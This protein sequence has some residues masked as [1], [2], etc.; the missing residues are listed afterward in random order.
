MPLE[1]IR[2]DIVN[3]RT[4]VIVN[5]T[6]CFLSG[7][8]GVDRRIHLSAGKE[9]D[10][11]CSSIGGCQTGK[12]VITSG[13]HLPCK[14]IIHTV[15]PVWKGGSSGEIKDLESCYL[16]ALSL[17]LRYNCKTAAFPIISAGS[18]GFPKELALKTAVGAIGR[19]L[20]EYDMT[21]YLVVF[22]KTVFNIGERLYS[23]IAEYIDDRY[24]EVYNETHGGYSRRLSESRECAR[25]EP[26]ATML[27][28]EFK[29]DAHGDYRA[30]LQKQ[31]K[32]LDESFSQMLLR[33]I[34]EKGMK[35]SECYKKANIDRK[36]FSKI[37]N[38]ANY[39]PSK[40]TAAA[41]AVALELTLPETQELMR[42]AGFAL[43]HSSKF[44]IIVEYFISRGVYDIFEINEA[45]FAFDQSILGGRI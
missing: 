34:D 1:I 23:D 27:A 21:V 5:A 2:N 18:F 22:D 42:K 20:N 39:R 9:L 25:E 12:A 4:D 44:D 32:S 14:Y 24:T 37:R 3:M 33:K 43:S 16:S 8:G 19:F 7:S 30:E 11:E 31:M 38:D 40:P 17:A 29:R 6:D 26:M 35:D 13:Y 10:A 15:G 28:P 45:L 41:F 36:L